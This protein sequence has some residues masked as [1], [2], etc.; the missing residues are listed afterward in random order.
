[1]DASVGS[2]AKQSD[3][4]KAGRDRAAEGRRSR[5][6]RQRGIE[7]EKKKGRGGSSNGG[8]GV[9]SGKEIMNS[10]LRR[11]GSNAIAM[12]TQILLSLPDLFST[13]LTSSIHPSFS[14]GAKR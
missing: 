2:G 7:S 5:K 14:L 1:M 9:K 4:Q 8:Q 10:G 13:N 6:G 12:I 3:R 11:K